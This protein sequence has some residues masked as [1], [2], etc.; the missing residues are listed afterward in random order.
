MGA[1]RR[2][3]VAEAQRFQGTAGGG[4]VV[5]GELDLGQGEE[6]GLVL[7]LQLNGAPDVSFRRREVPALDPFEQAQ[8]VVGGTEVR[9][10]F[11]VGGNLRFEAFILPAPDVLQV[12]G[13]AG[14]SPWRSTDTVLGRR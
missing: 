4:G 13:G 10:P 3:N 9:Q 7:R 12:G 11:R 2:V 1:D 5:P 8:E 6:I 14:A